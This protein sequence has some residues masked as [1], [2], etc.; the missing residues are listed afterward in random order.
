[1]NEYLH[2]SQTVFNNRLFQ[3][4]YI[5]DGNEKKYNCIFFILNWSNVQQIPYW[6]SCVDDEEFEINI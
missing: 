2:E 6:C 4:S 5:F 3:F 1:M